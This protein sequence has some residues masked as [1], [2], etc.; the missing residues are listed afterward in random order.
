VDGLT[1]SP[2]ILELPGPA[3]GL[4]DLR[5]ERLPLQGER[6]PAPRGRQAPRLRRAALDLLQV[7]LRGLAEPPETPASPGGL[8]LPLT[9]GLPP[10]GTAPGPLEDDPPFV[11]EDDLADLLMTLVDP[12]SW[13]EDGTLAEVRGGELLVVNRPQTISQVEQFVEDLAELLPARFRLAVQVEEAPLGEPPVVVHRGDLILESGRAGASSS[14]RPS[15]Y[16]RDQDPLPGGVLDPV[17]G[18]L[19]GGTRVLVQ[20]RVQAEQGL[21]VDL[22]FEHQVPDPVPLPIQ[23]GVELPVVR[24]VALATSAHL[25]WNT[26]TAVAEL[27]TA[28]HRYV[29]TLTAYLP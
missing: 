1:D 7:D 9:G 16:L 13:E 24:G 21:R 25:D 11:L 2:R 20:P 22:R 15:R 19:V 28:T 26:P 18:V 27:A 4:L 29:L 23:A 3:G 6:T 10:A 5:L 8:L 17:V 14:L 12:A